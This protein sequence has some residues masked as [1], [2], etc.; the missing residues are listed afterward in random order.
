LCVVGRKPKY[1]NSSDSFE[2]DIAQG[3]REARRIK[4]FTCALAASVGESFSRRKAR[5]GA[6]FKWCL[7]DWLRGGECRVFQVRLCGCW[8]WQWVCYSG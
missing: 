2:S 4:T 5:R 1:G 3:F 8:P 6:L 7:A